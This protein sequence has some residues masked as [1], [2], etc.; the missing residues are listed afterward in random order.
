MTDAGNRA[1]GIPAA[2]WSAKRGLGATARLYTRS[3][4]GS[5]PTPKRAR[6]MQA[7]KKETVT[8]KACERLERKPGGILPFRGAM[9]PSGIPATHKWSTS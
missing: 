9:L 3:I 1:A 8:L 2:S 4:P 7:T 6:R 5:C